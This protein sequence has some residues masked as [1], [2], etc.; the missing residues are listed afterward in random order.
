[1]IFMSWKPK[2]CPFDVVIQHH[3]DNR[4]KMSSRLVRLDP[5][6]VIDEYGADALRMTLLTGTAPGNDLRY[7]P[8]KVEASRNF[9]NK[10]WNA[11]RFA[12]M[13]LEDFEPDGK[14]IADRELEL[15]DRW[16]L[17]RYN[18]TVHGGTP[19]N[20]FDFSEERARCVSLDGAV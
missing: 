13:N 2:A 9:A 17:S 12:L 8:E 15:A 3:R 6:E 14:H 11:A 7:Y 16:I 10:V 5:L 4:R 19:P 18:W 1:M 20:R